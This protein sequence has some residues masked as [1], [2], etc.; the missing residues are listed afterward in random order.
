MI[1]NSIPHKLAAA[2]PYLFR[3]F[4]MIS[5]YAAA[6][7]AFSIRFDQNTLPDEY[8]GLI[9]TALFV[10]LTIT[11]YKTI[12]RSFRG[13]YGFSLFL[14]L[15]VSWFVAGSAVM[16]Y[17]V[18]SHEAEY[19]SRIWLVLWWSLILI[20]MIGSRAI[21]YIS[22]AALRTKGIDIKNV[23]LVGL[24]GSHSNIEKTLNE[25]T[26]SG[27]KVIS[28]FDL[29]VLN[30]DHLSDDIKKSD[31]DEV[32]ICLPLTQSEQVREILHSLRHVSRNIRFIPGVEDLRLLNHNIHQVASINMITLSASPLNGI[33]SL[34]KRIEDI[35]LGILFFLIA[36]PL[37][38]SVA[39]GV[40]LS[41][42]G[43]VLFKQLR[44][45]VGGREISVYK[46]RSMAI[47]SE[48][49]GLVTQAVKGDQRI[50]KFGAFIRRTS[51]D[52]LPQF[53]NVIRGQ[54]SIVGPRPHALAHN[55]EFKEQVESYM[56]R[57]KIKPG[58]TGWAQVNGLRGETDTLEKMKKRVEFDL[59]Y[60]DN[61]SLWFDMKVI[62]MTV[63]TGFINKNAY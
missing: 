46:F 11:S 10:V 43:P 27:F 28:Y 63:F 40:K 47:H 23:H 4:D 12:Y 37:M 56:A 35:I 25:N 44:H 38:V 24:N 14:N 1:T 3:L 42:K 34:I 32:W 52:E 53:W 22:L 18:F 36:L 51:L 16:A 60:L 62:V 17:L 19:F 54:M 30:I 57:H 20:L 58:I 45:G 6:A 29:A 9:I 39:I 61:W 5:V 55:E 48:D 33:N 21:V 50:T 41:S 15:F 8:M 2:S 7:I 26:W 49:N 13:Q 31:A 59:Y